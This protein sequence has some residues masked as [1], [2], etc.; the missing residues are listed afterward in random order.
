ME[1]CEGF[2]LLFAFRPYAGLRDPFNVIVI[3][4]N[5]SLGQSG[6]PPTREEAASQRNKEAYE[7]RYLG[8]THAHIGCSKAPPEV[9]LQEPSKFYSRA[10]ERHAKK[11]FPLIEAMRVDRT[12]PLV[13]SALTSPTL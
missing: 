8:R 5:I 3:Y 9:A 11:A 4:R 1:N 12:S 13:T 2:H 10:T 7:Q 6:F